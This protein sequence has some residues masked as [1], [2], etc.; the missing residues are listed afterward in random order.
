MIALIHSS[1]KGGERT[2]TVALVSALS[3]Q[4]D[5]IHLVPSTMASV[6]EEMLGQ[7]VIPYDF[8]VQ[9]FLKFYR[10][11]VLRHADF[12]HC[13]GLRA[14]T[15][16]RF[17]KLFNRSIAPI[18]VTVHGFHY[19]RYANPIQK[20]VFLWIEALLSRVQTATIA[21]SQG[22]L[23]ALQ[24]HH[25][26]HHPIYLIPNGISRCTSISQSVDLAA[27]GIVKGRDTVV[28]TTGALE[29]VKGQETL[30]RS[31]ALLR[32]SGLFLK[33]IMI[34]EGSLRARFERLI[35]Q[36][37]LQDQ[38][39]LIGTCNQ[40]MDW[41]ACADLFVFPSHYEGLSYSLLEAMQAGVPIIASNVVGCNELIRHF[42]TGLL[43]EKG[44]FVDL[45]DKIHY[46]LS[47]PI[48]C[49]QWTQTARNCVETQ[50]SEKKMVTAVQ[51]IYATFLAK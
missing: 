24:R 45:C 19:A 5:F 35:Q 42:E 36:N 9:S 49:D 22:D 46:A 11:P 28:V 34:G 6:A 33:V 15:W 1:F 4:Y 20:K 37:Q 26:T 30:I 29:P 41:L 40:V 51:S 10:D 50:Y 21:I 27:Y 43:F 14:A 2:H 39:F 17:L 47:H 38:V 25:C 18:L 8:S 3:A 44:S 7:P 16:V 13:H 23:D 32:K 12:I 48:E 31:I